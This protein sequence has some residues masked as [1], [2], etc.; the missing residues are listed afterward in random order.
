MASQK[1]HFR[2]PSHALLLLL[3]TLLPLL[4]LLLLSVGAGAGAACLVNEK[5]PSAE[6][7]EAAAAT[8]RCLASAA[9]QPRVSIEPTLAVARH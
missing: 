1:R 4:L 3:A 5:H 2:T 8:G 7:D 6:L 9:A